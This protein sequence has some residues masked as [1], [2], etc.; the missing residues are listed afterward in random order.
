MFGATLR[1]TFVQFA[2]LHRF[3]LAHHHSCAVIIVSDSLE[4]DVN[5]PLVPIYSV[6]STC[7]QIHYH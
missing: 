5:I 4:D 6:Y 2:C 1:S 3:P 7:K